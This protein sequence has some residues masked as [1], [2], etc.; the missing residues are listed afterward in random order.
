MAAN[1]ASGT[2]PQLSSTYANVINYIRERDEDVAKQFNTPSSNAL[3]GTNHVTGTIRWDGATSK[4]SLYGGSSW[5]DLSSTYAINVSTVAS[6]APN[7]ASGANNLPRNNGSL[8]SNLISQ[9]LGASAQD[10]AFFRNATNLNAGTIPSAR[11]TGTYGISVTGNSA[12]FTVAENNTTDETVYPV[13]VDGATGTQGAET[14]TGLTYNPSSGL[15]TTTTVAGNLTGNVTGNTSGSSGSC[16]GLSATATALATA[17]TVGMTGDVVWTS[18]AFNGSGN[19][20]GTA[21]IQANTVDNSELVN[22]SNIQLGGLG[23]GTA[24]ASGEIRATGTVT[25]H[26]SD[27]RLKIKTGTI[28]NA[29][30]K[31]NSLTGFKY[32]ENSL[33]NSLGFT[34]GENFVGVSA[35]ELQ[36]VLPEAVKPAPF[37]L[38]ENNKSISGE[39]YLTVQYEKIVPLLVESIKELK[40]LI[41]YQSE[42][43][44]KLKAHQKF[45]S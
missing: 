1:W 24:G 44:E 45:T 9:Y 37:D 31:V 39:N 33:A 5:A 11:L 34:T 43:I 35:Q 4:W 40:Y 7:N 42:E 21:A 26:Y 25:A 36:K 20:T 10:D 17:R 27:E 16:T 14:D 6:C 38:G 22:N 15:L 28:N 3:L 18:A 32:I 19:V 30:N 12:T 13:F 29:L 23:V 41:E 2:D 8:Q